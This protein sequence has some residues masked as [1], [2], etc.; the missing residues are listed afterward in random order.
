MDSRRSLDFADRHPLDEG[1]RDLRAARVPDPIKA[2]S[3]AAFIRVP[4]VPY[5]HHVPT[6]RSITSPA[7]FKRDST[8]ELGRAITSLQTQRKGH[9]A[10]PAQQSRGFLDTIAVHQQSLPERR[11]EI[12][13][14]RGRNIDR[15]LLRTRE[16]HRTDDPA[17]HPDRP[18]TPASASESSQ[19]PSQTTIA[20]SS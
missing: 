14:V 9:G 17:R 2:L 20:L 12:A 15:R 18:D 6:A 10:R 19:A 4:A 5:A 16:A 1:Q 11:T 13:S 8:Q 3:R 7:G